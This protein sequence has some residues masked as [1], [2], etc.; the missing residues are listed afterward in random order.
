LDD[1]G[2]SNNMIGD[3]GANVS[4]QNKESISNMSSNPNIMA[5]QMVNTSKF[6]YSLFDE[7]E[8]AMGVMDQ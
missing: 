7:T 8:N 1:L 5:S 2:D 3:L 6:H 4:S